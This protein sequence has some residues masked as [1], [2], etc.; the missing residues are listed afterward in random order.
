LAERHGL[1]RDHLGHG[2][3]AAA[4]LDLEVDALILE[5]ALFLAVVE[6][7]MLAID[8]PVEHQRHLVGRHGRPGDRQRQDCEQNFLHRIPPFERPLSDYRCFD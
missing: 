4:F 3:G 2:A 1:G 5:V 8:V 6:R 7:R